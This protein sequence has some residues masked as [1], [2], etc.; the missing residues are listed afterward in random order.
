[1]VG[2][3]QGFLDWNKKETLQI[4]DLKLHTY[5]VRKPGMFFYQLGGFNFISAYLEIN[6]V[7][8]IEKYS[9]NASSYNNCT[10]GNIPVNV[11]DEVKYQ[12]GYYHDFL[13]AVVIFVPFK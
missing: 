2:N 9:T 1:M 4:T 11:G 3:L 10:T 5:A 8:I 13:N 6:K 12:T 7:I